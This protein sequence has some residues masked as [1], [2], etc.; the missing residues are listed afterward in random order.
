MQLDLPN[1]ILMLIGGSYIMLRFFEWTLTSLLLPELKSPK[2]VKSKAIDAL[3]GI[4]LFLAIEVI[5]VF[6][7]LI[8]AGSS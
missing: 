2:N 1:K 4:S 8:V 6:L 5:I 3:L 7:V